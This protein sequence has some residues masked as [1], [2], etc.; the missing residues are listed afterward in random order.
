[1]YSGLHTD[2]SPETTAIACIHLNALV[3]TMIPPKKSFETIINKTL[4]FTI[5][6]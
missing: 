5:Y 1:M 2:Q 3:L 6:N 4:L